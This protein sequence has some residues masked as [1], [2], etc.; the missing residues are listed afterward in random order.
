MKLMR[1]LTWPGLKEHIPT[2]DSGEALDTYP[3]SMIRW[4]MRE[5]EDENEQG[6]I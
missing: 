1:S 5:V 6:G 4:G 2:G 3:K